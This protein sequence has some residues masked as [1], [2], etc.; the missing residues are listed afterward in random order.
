MKGSS[1]AGAFAY[2][3][4]TLQRHLA[5]ISKAHRAVG[6]DDPVGSE[7]VKSTMRGI[8]RTFGIAQRQA[9]ALLRDELFAMLNQLGQRRKDVRDRALLLLGFTTAMRRSQLV[10]LDVAEV[11]LVPRVCS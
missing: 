2:A 3:V 9:K 8:R 1:D 7:L 10:A 4:A 5:A 6:N 11:E